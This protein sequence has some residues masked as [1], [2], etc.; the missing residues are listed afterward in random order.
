MKHY[1]IYFNQKREDWQL[2]YRLRQKLESIRLR[3][4]RRIEISETVKRC[5]WTAVALLSITLV[6]LLGLSL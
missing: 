5:Y 3:D 1:G 6:I 2:Y 4:A